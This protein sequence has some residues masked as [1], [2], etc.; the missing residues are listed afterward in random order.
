MIVQMLEVLLTVYILILL[1]KL[2]FYRSDNNN[3][4]VENYGDTVQDRAIPN[5]IRTFK[6]A[7][8]DFRKSSVIHSFNF[9]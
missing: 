9:L 1:I 7:Y 3:I 2:P 4:I 5:P 8:A 6:E